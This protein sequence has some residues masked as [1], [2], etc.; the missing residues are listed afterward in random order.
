MDILLGLSIGIIIGLGIGIG[1]AYLWYQQQQSGLKDTQD[2]FKSELS[3]QM[4]EMI[5][6]L[7]S[8]ALKQNTD[9]FMQLAGEKLKHQGTVHEK[10]L[11]GK[12]GLIDQ[13]LVS[14]KK[15]LDTVKTTMQSLEKDREQKFGQLS[16]QL[17]SSHEQTNLL[18]NTTT[19]LKEALASSKIR[20]QWGERMAEDVLRLS[21]FI[22]G[23]NYSKQ[24]SLD[25][26]RNIPDFTFHLP[27]DMTLN[28]DVKFPL[29]QYMNYLESE[30]EH[31]REQFKKEFMKDVK[32]RIKEVASKDYINPQENTL[33]YVLVFIP[34]EQVY[35][36]INEENRE[37][38]DIALAQKV[39]FCSPMTLY[40]LLAVIRQAIDNFT[41]EKKAHEMLKH[42]G[43]F[44]KQWQRFK[45]SMEKMGKRIEDSQKEYTNLMTT[46]KNQLDKPLLKIEALKEETTDNSSLNDPSPDDKSIP[47]EEVFRLDGA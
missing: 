37:I 14:M 27:K 23:V 8:D 17:K 1:A 2:Q 25:Y 10:E 42:L 45:E 46:R 33:D 30:N 44:N 41:F 3:T 43:E 35:G 38:L 28:M 26:S 13:T 12:K 31:E 16:S 20:G 47:S 21:G 6:S 29:R 15:E 24:R 18:L 39:I 36:F 9:Q 40:A 11:D 22:E 7:S 4:R 32:M 5:G 19:Q 34:N